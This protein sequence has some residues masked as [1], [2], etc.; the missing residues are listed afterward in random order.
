[1]SYV[2]WDMTILLLTATGFVD[3]NAL[4]LYVYLSTF[5][6]G[7]DESVLTVCGLVLYAW[8]HSTKLTSELVLYYVVHPVESVW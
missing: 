8:E 5:D 4:I 6:D 7:V 2:L 3:D 1:M